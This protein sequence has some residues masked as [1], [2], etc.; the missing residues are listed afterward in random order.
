MIAVRE[1]LKPAEGW[2]NEALI[3]KRTKRNEFILGS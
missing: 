3:K 2:E 1:S